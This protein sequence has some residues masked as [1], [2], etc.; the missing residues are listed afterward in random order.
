VLTRKECCGSGSASHFGK[1]DPDLDQDGKLDSD[2][3]QGGKLNS[4]PH[5]I[6][7][8][9]PDPHL[10]EKVEAL[11]GHFGPLECPNLGKNEW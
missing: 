2:P 1:L 8:K 9:D 11:E 5:Q 4:D 7:K 6:K 3:D 10:S